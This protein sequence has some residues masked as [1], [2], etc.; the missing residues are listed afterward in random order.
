VVAEVPAA[1]PANVEA[2]WAYAVEHL[3]KAVPLAKTYLVGA[4]LLGMTGNVVTVGFDP[5]FAAQRDFVDTA[6]NREVLLAKLKEQL[7]RDVVLKFE[8]TEAAAPVLPAAGKPAAPAK[9]APAA[10]KGGEDFTNDPLIK[11]ALEIFKAT[12]IDVR[13]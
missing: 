4:R 8:V 2:A 13:K 6:R 5:E 10:K 11:Q 7:R 12:I 9:P 3:G 1:P